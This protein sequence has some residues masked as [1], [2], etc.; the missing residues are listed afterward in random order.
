MK[1]PQTTKCQTIVT[2]AECPNCGDLIYSRARHDFHRCSCGE[3][4]IDGG[5]DY[6]KMAFKKIVPKQQQIE[7]DATKKEL[8]DDWNKRMDKFGVI[9]KNK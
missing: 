8:Y 2:A 4:A 7:I 1:N 3:I 6:V 9:K 5:F